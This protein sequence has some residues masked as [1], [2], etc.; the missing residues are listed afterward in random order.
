MSTY[1]INKIWQEHV[2]SVHESFNEYLNKKIIKNGNPD[3]K[4]IE[5]I[6]NKGNYIIQEM[7][8]QNKEDKKAL[9]VGHVQS[10]KTMNFLS[11]INSSL[12]YEYKIV[13]ILTS[14]ENELHYQT[15]ER[16]KEAFNI[17]ENKNYL[18]IFDWSKEKLEPHELKTNV[19]NDCINIIAL[20][21]SKTNEIKDLL[22]VEYF[23]NK[24]VLIIDDE[25]DLGSMTHTKNDYSRTYKAIK[26]LLKVSNPL[27]ISVTATPQVHIVTSKMESLFP[28]RVFCIEP[29]EGYVGLDYFMEPTKFEKTF[30]YTDNLMSTKNDWVREEIF[31]DSILYFLIV[32]AYLVQDNIMNKKSHMNMLVHTNI[33][34]SQHE[35]YEKEITKFINLYKQNFS[36]DSSSFDKETS[37]ERFQNVIKKYDLNIKIDENLIEKLKYIISRTFCSEINQK[38]K[39]NKINDNLSSI[40]VGSK[41]LERGITLDNL[42]VTFFTNRAKS[43][44]S[45]DTLLQRARWFGYRT[46]VLEYIKIFTT[47][48]IAEDFK[49]IAIHNRQLWDLLKNADEKSL[50]FDLI[51]TAI[52]MLVEERSGNKLKLTNKAPYKRLG[53]SQRTVM[54]D[55]N[56]LS[57]NIHL[58][59]NLVNNVLSSNDKLNVHNLYNFKNKWLNNVYELFNYISKEEFIRLLGIDDRMTKLL[60]DKIIENKYRINVS[61]LD[62]DDGK[63]SRIRS[64]RASNIEKNVYYIDQ[65]FQGKNENYIG[66]GY[67]NNINEYK[68]V[69]F[70]QIHKVKPEYEKQNILKDDEWIYVPALI[71]PNDLSISSFNTIDENY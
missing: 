27:Y 10:G 60:I 53:L 12:N 29:G 59:D 26:S 64:C 49:N 47:K 42:I 16:L 8:K 65:V 58:F 52:P 25:G 18:K 20:L 22:S 35:I 69:V 11:V 4:N 21:K 66:D 30:V 13:V 44:T 34:V 67:W 48:Q 70:L 2:D 15:L 38:N 14:F 41:K 43:K 50:S 40:L 33:K 51:D 23:Q 28:K 9:I 32:A 55:V 57:K 17:N 5:K 56:F 19:E 54:N 31:K 45:I 61:V 1:N 36:D 6:L 3:E 71:L 68:D 24:K 62:I 46:K 37:I 7:D 63:K 39:S